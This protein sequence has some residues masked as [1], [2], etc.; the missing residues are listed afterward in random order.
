MNLYD[1]DLVAL[2]TLFTAWG[3]PAVHARTVWK[4]LYR[5]I[6]T[7]FTAL[8][9]T[10][11]QTLQARLRAEMTLELPQAVDSQFTADGSTRKDLLQLADGERVEVV[12]MRYR[13]RH[14]ACISTQVG[15]A[16]ACRFCATGQM[17]FM[18]QLRAAE[19]VAQVLHAQRI[20]ATNGQ[21]LTNFVLM[22]M[23]EPLLNYDNTLTAL[24]RLCDPRGMGFVE[25]RITLSTVGIVP[26][27]ERLAGEKLRINLAVSL[28]A[29]TDA[30]RDALLPL[31]RRY[32]LDD[33]CD[34]LRTYTAITQRRVM[35]EWVMIDGL[36]DT[37]EQAGALVARFAGIPVHVNLIQL[38][39]TPEYA[40]RPSS[41][42]AVD[43][44]STILDQ[45]G[46]PHT[47]RQRRGVPIAAACGQLRRRSLLEE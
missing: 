20:L 3:V 11:P 8:P 22:G 26:G 19:I 25:R 32:P 41:P 39:P 37:R 36:N 42:E 2:E 33:L 35:L 14:S 10:L 24:R 34:A 44:F 12:I 5:C 15:C 17:G 1:L 16:C 40:E 38:N 13:H 46:I 31:N 43:A 7:D 21:T 9:P 45:A 23:G 4:W 29:A 27:I 6:P 30:V 47:L 28:H 18:R